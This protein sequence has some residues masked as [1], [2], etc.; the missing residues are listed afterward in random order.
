MYFW[1]EFFHGFLIVISFQNVI[2]KN[3]DFW[4][5]GLPELVEPRVQGGFDIMR[6]DSSTTFLESIQDSNFRLGIR[7]GTAVMPLDSGWAGWALAH[8]ESGV[9][10]NP[11]PTREGRLCPPYYCLPTRVWKPNGNPARILQQSKKCEIQVNCC[12]E[13]AV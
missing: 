1:T 5:K 4:Q 13:I 7:V 10:L 6:V 11:I 12:G 9:T 8:P 2:E 3:C